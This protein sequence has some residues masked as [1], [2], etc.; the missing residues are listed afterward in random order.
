MENQEAKAA[1]LTVEELRARVVISQC[2]A[3]GS[4]PDYESVEVD[5]GTAYQRAVDPMSVL[6]AR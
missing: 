4:A 5:G 2:P 3:C 1:A 6:D